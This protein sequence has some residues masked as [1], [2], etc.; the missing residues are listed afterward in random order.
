LEYFS[1]FSSEMHLHM[2]LHIRHP[3]AE[4]P[5]FSTPLGLTQRNTHQRDLEAMRKRPCSAGASASKQPALCAVLMS[6]P[7]CASFHRAPLSQAF[8]FYALFLLCC[9]KKWK[10][11]A[12]IRINPVLFFFL[13][14]W[15]GA[16][17]NRRSVHR[18]RAFVSTQK[19][20]P[21]RERCPWGSYGS[22]IKNC[23]CVFLLFVP[24]QWPSTFVLR[25]SSS[26]TSNG[27][28]R[29]WRT[30]LYDWEGSSKLKKMLCGKFNSL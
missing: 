18:I 15:M 6:H 29:W 23:A 20:R 27:A 13:F 12:S 25:L 9:K 11:S 19:F 17:E 26:L 1:H 2:T 30:K 10:R 22:A 16:G 7:R 14:P 5:P 4:T 8:F 21:L 3:K 24:A 28:D